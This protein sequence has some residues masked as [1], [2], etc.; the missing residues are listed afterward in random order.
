MGFH[1]VLTRITQ[2]T[3]GNRKNGF[4]SGRRL[5]CRG[6]RHLA[7]RNGRMNSFGIAISF[8]TTLY[9]SWL[10]FRRAER[11][12]STAGVTPAATLLARALLNRPWT[13]V[14]M[15]KEL[16]VVQIGFA[17]FNPK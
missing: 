17:L 11:R 8:Q 16:T 15:L 3:N 9:D 2:L 13:Q 5:A 1:V 6:G 7:A 12:G 14:Q 10:Y 4:C